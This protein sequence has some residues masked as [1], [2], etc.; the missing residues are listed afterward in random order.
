[1]QGQRRSARGSR[2]IGACLAACALALVA[3]DTVP[4]NPRYLPEAQQ[5]MWA[6]RL[7][8][9]QQAID[10]ASSRV[11]RLEHAYS[12]AQHR[13]YPRGRDRGVLVADLAQAR[14]DLEEARQALPRLVE[15][16]RRAGVYPEVLRP[17]KK[18]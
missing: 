5:K 18:Q 14:K 8:E 1:M 4:D 10:E 13:Q 2:L 3:A 11:T 17:Y 9:A 6:D 15:E 16:A 7:A 12:E